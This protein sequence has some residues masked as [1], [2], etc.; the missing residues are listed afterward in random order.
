MSL[1][2]I[3]FCVGKLNRGLLVV[4]SLRFL[5]KEEVFFEKDIFNVC[6]FGWCIEW[7]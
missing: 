7:V 2:W 5:K 1:C 4:D 3:G 6:V